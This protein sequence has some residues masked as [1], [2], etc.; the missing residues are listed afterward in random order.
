MQPKAAAGWA[1][2]PS[3]SAPHDGL[4]PVPGALVTELMNMSSENLANLN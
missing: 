2:R 3:H 1:G 4:N